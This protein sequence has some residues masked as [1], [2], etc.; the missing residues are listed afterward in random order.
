MHKCRFR[1]LGKIVQLWEFLSF[2]SVF[3][4]LPKQ[5]SGEPIA[6][7]GRCNTC[8]FPYNVF[9]HHQ[10][11]GKHVTEAFEKLIAKP[12]SKP[13]LG[14]VH[15]SQTQFDRAVTFATLGTITHSFAVLPFI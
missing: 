12:D 11:H 15:Q 4:G 6:D 8:W 7:P 3:F 10:A 5:S 9:L 2:K 1:V 13:K 14:L